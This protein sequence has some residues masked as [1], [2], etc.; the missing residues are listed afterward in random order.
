MAPVQILLAIILAALCFA[1]VESFNGGVFQRTFSQKCSKVKLWCK[2]REEGPSSISNPSPPK[3]E[4][5]R[6]DDDLDEEE[7]QREL[8]MHDKI[9][10][11]DLDIDLISE[12]DADKAI[13]MAI[14]N[15]LG[16]K[17]PEL[18][19]MEKFDKLY[20]VR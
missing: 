19:P 2:P 17:E 4:A 11:E 10:D 8:D 6:D 3:A 12:S 16:P 1:V 20:K 14:K 15:V 18:S 7:I 5:K 13:E 9:S